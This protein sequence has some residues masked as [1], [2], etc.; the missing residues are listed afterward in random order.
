MYDGYDSFNDSGASSDNEDLDT[1]LLDADEDI[2]DQDEGATKYRFLNNTDGMG[3]TLF[4]FLNIH[5][6]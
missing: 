5:F 4:F 1:S 2:L 6:Y 3:I